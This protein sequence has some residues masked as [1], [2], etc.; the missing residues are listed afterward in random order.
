M[1]F[2]A[3]N[4]SASALYAQRVKLDTIASNIANANTT[5]NADG[6]PGTY[7]RKE[8]V[9]EAIYNDAVNQYS[10]SSEFRPPELEGNLLKGGI[11]SSSGMMTNGVAVSQIVE[12]KNTDFRRIYN[13]GHPDAD[14]DGFVNMPNINVVTEMVDMIAA[15]RAYEANVTTMEAS[16]SMISAA[17]RI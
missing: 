5:R 7:K 17:M 3:L 9:F 15:S 2:D 8:V 10:S 1:S 13:P 14:K 4:I 6:T 16:K 12:D 11:S